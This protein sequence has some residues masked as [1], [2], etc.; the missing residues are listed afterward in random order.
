VIFGIGTDIVAIKRIEEGLFKHDERFVHRILSEAEVAEYTKHTSSA[1]PHAAARFLA[2]RFAA[3]EAFSKAFGTGIG[4][5]VGWHDV[6][7][8]HDTK[9]KPLLAV[10]APLQARLSEAGVNS[11]HISISDEQDHAIAFVVLES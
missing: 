5:A 2:K 7:V 3:K 11:M 8:T 9:G 6:C 10:S 1:N 4:D